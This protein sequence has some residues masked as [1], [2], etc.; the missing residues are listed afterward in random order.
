M[1][2]LIKQI[3]SKITGSSTAISEAYMDQA[4]QGTAFPFVT[5]KF[6][7]SNATDPSQD[8]FLEVDVWDRNT[9]A[10]RVETLT[11]SIDTALHKVVIRTSTGF[12][13]HF[14]RVN[15]LAI[16][17]FDSVTGASMIKRRQLRYLVRTYE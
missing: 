17:N 5:F 11:N 14:Q 3:K 13:A 8:H 12:N 10:T 6:P 2:T 15:R 4:P 16:P 7:T 9:S 1:N